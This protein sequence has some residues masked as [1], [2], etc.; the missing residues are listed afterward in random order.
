MRPSPLLLKIALF[1]FLLPVLVIVSG[2]GT[3]GLTLAVWALLALAI[4]AD[5]VASRPRGKL[6]LHIDMPSEA[7][8][9]EDIPVRFSIADTSGAAPAGMRCRLHYPDGLSGPETMAFVP[10]ET[11]SEARASLW[12]KRRGAWSFDRLWL[13]WPGRFGLIEFVPSLTMEQKLVILPNIRPISSG[14]IDVMVRSNMFGVKENAMRGEGSDF[15]Q[16]RDFT[17]G[18]D[19][20]S[21]DWKRSASHR[22]LV[23]KEMRA[24]R[25]HHIILAL[26]NGYLMREEIAGLPKIDHQINAALAIAWAAVQGGD[27]IGMFAFDV[28]PRFFLPPEGGRSAFAHLR[29]RAGELDYRSV[30]TNHTLAAAFLQA[31][32]KR[33]SLIVI[34][35]DFVDTTT[36]EL[37]L[38]NVSVLNKRH[39]IVF[40]TLGDPELTTVTNSAPGNLTDVARSVSAEQ[41]LQERRVVLDRLRRLGVLCIEAGPK[42]MTASLISTYLQ[43]KAREMV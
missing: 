1:A 20:R 21:I 38:E 36:A 40:A 24:E 17:T 4:L 29:S 3:I 35:S 8:S 42:Q 27:Q 15:H 19:V 25:N 33:R 41:F 10:T 34:F 12:G 9:G 37:L 5:I 32:L 16:L 2:R 14:Q 39:L 11:G 23:A 43:I 22:S 28:K 30:E 26:D 7:F 31:R 13:F 6:S 18:M